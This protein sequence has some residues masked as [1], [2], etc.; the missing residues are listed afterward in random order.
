MSISDAVPSLSGHLLRDFDH[1]LGTFPLPELKGQRIFLTGGTGFVGYWLL[2]AC[3]WLNNHGAGI[4]V[5]VLSR[6]PERF[7]QSHPEY[8][9]LDWLTWHKG[10]IKNYAIPSQPFDAF[11]HGAADTSPAASRRISLYADIDQG[12]QHALEHAELAGARRIL[13]ISSGAVYG[14]DS[15]LNIPIKEESSEFTPPLA[16][17]DFYGRGKRL[18]EEIGLGWSRNRQAA[19]TI[20]RC[21]SFAG[22]GLPGH[23]ATS[24]FIR[25]ALFEPEIRVAGDGRAIRSLLYAADM[26]VWLLAV[27]TRGRNGRAYNV[28][29]ADAHSMLEIASTVRDQ[30]SPGKPI[31][32]LNTEKVSPRPFYVPNIQRVTNELGVS[33]WTSTAQGLTRMSSSAYPN[34]TQSPCK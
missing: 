17:D 12:T 29:S 7:L 13:L 6:Q 18:M 24:Q 11:I 27:L 9:S 3:R 8:K 32:V 30:S 5:T 10:D 23:L 4:R 2:L 16:V 22:F 28:G 25:D 20:G 15:L 19:L 14:T 26:A 21:F 1:I 33:V 31:R 34:D